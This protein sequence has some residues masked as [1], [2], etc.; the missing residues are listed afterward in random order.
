LPKGQC[1]SGQIREPIDFLLNY[2]NLVNNIQNSIDNISPWYKSEYELMKNKDDICLIDTYFD[3]CR[4]I[5]YEIETCGNIKN[6]Y[7]M[8]F[9]HI[10]KVYDMAKKNIRKFRFLQH[11][12]VHFK[13][14][15]NISYTIDKYYTDYKDCIFPS[16]SKDDC[17]GELNNA[18]EKF[19]LGLIDLLKIYKRGKTNE[20]KKKTSK[21][22]K[23]L[24]TP[25]EKKQEKL[26]NK[27]KKFQNM[28]RAKQHIKRNPKNIY[29]Y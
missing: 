26:E 5:K 19:R 6:K 16:L 2:I 21:V 3:H 27:N 7:K 1:A 18:N 23:M 29:R 9:D 10:K 13:E 17:E 11:T 24:K 22:I 8:A 20:E 15:K 25:E 12:R 4:N 28:M 14:N